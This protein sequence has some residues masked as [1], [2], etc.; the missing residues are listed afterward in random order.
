M[1]PGSLGLTCAY[2]AAPAIALAGDL[3]ASA[4]P[5]DAH[6]GS[7]VT[8]RR[9]QIQAGQDWSATFTATQQVVFIAVSQVAV[10]WAQSANGLTNG[11]KNDWSVQEAVFD[12]AGPVTVSIGET[13]SP[14]NLGPGIVL[15]GAAVL[16]NRDQQEG[17]RGSVVRVDR[18]TVT[19]VAP[20]GHDRQCFAIGGTADHIVLWCNG[21]NV[22]G[23]TA[24]L[25]RS[26]L[27]VWSPDG[28]LRAIGVDGIP[29]WIDQAWI[30]GDQLVWSEAPGP[31]PG[32]PWLFGSVP[33]SAIAA[34]P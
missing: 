4:L 24:E 31:S 14:A 23:D 32:D 13:A 27:A 26:W 5:A 1:L 11:E 34:L 21:S 19:T 8:V 30:V 33:L 10:A 16:A 18:G 17:G 6:H 22:I 15:D 25:M 29:Y 7:A 9:L 28:G 3:L 2:P 12:G 20:E